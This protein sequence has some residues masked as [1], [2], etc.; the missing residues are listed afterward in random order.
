MK[1]IALVSLGCAKNLVDSEV[2]LGL[3]EEKNYEPVPHLREADIIVINT[4]G[5]IDPARRESYE[6]IK[7]ALE[8]KKRSKKKKIIVSGCYVQKNREELQKSFPH[9]D[10]W[11]GVNDFDKIASIVEGYPYEK[12]EKCFLYDHSFPRRISTPP[13]WTYVKI[14]EGCS[15]NC[16]FCSIPL[17][18]GSYR[19][20]S[21][22][23]ITQEV[24]KFVA[25]GVKEINLVSQDSTAFGRDLKKK[26][27]LVQLLEELLKIKNLGWIRIL[28]SYPEEVSDSLL[29]IL[30]EEKIC[31][32]L[33]IP[34]QHSHPLIIKRMKRGLDG[35][36]SL[37]LL[38]K[39]RK[40][41]PEIAVRTSLVVGFP[42]ERKKEFDDLIAFIKAACFDH[43]GVF[44]YSMEV[45][46]DCQRFG[47][48]VKE[49]IK[50]RRRNKIMA[51][52]AEISLENNKK[53]KNKKMDVLIEGTLKQ[54]PRVIVGRGKFQA[55]EVDGLI[56]IISDERR[57]EVL[58]SIQKVEITDT[59]VY[60]LQG[61]LI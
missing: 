25:S 23:S 54:E 12:S 61:E 38:E 17:I 26:E 3:L 18:K 24:E 29:E 45:G 28:Y 7:Q 37:K 15:H 58:N 53:Y 27:G 52:Q 60:D 42:G 32:Y 39:I 19:S 33:D 35:K 59:D 4:C 51:I 34:F 8:E 48:P 55:P 43:L 40:K 10:E 49:N 57:P 56:M 31:S 22:S 21:I 11:I 14:S 30:N 36:K 46:T 47:D 9:V 41:V 20:R 2:M 5:F 13:G 44:S 6:A 16:S 1:K 50:K